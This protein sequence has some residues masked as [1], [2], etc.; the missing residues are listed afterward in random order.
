MSTLPAGSRLL[1]F[2]GILVNLVIFPLNHIV[3]SGVNRGDYTPFAV[4]PQVSA[5]IFDETQL[6]VPG[7]SR[8]FRTGQVRAELDTFELRDLPN[9]YPVLHSVLV[10]LFAKSLGS[11]EW[12]WM[13]SHAIAP[14]LIWAVFFWIACSFVRSGPLAMAIAWAVC[15]IAFGPR[16]FLLLAKDRFIQP[17]ELTRMPQPGLAFLFLILAIWLLARA[18]ARPKL[19]RILTGGILAGSLFYIYYFYWIAFFAGAGALLIVVAMIG[20]WDYVKT[21]A[22]VIVLGCLAGIPFFL[23][24]IEAMR[25]GHQRQLMMRVGSFTRTPNLTGLALALALLVALWL[26]CK[27]RMGG[28]PDQQPIF[29]AVLLAIATGAAIGIN[30]QLVTGFDAQHGHFYNRALQPLLMYFSCCCCSGARE[31]PRLPLPLPSLGFSS[32]WP[33]CVKLR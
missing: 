18:L 22:S 17:L 4:V 9:S 25:A 10:G 2:V 15:F 16:N 14:A 3:G 5:Q 7:P 30:F 13:V 11:L 21:T 24:T 26:Y 31:S 32:P 33:P 20:K 23:W 6:Y 27:L 1:L 8:F 28:Q 12:G 29:A 19:L